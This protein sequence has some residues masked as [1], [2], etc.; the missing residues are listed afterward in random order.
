MI[1]RPKFF[2]LLLALSLLSACALPQADITPVPA[3]LE[4]LDSL[5]LI[6]NGFYILFDTIGGTFSGSFKRFASE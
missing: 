5:W 2:F 3:T 4:A 1:A 6:D